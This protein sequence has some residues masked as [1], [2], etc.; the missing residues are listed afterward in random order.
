MRLEEKLEFF[1]LLL[2]IGFKEI[3]ISFPSAAQVEFDF[4]RKLIEEKL[5]PDDVTI[6]VL[7]QSREH[8]IERTFAA[9]KGAKRTVF[10]LYNSLS[11]L[12]RRVVFQKDRAAIK[13]IALNGIRYARNLA[14]DH[15]GEI[16]L[17]YS[18]ESFTG[19]EIDY[20]LEVCEAVC[21]AW[22]ATPQNK[23][24]LNLPATVELSTPNVY[25]DLVEIFTRS[26]SCRDSVIISLHTHND[27]GTAVAATEL[28]LMAGA[29]RVEGTLFGNGERTGNVDLV[30]LALNLFTQ[31]VDPHLDFRPLKRIVSEYNRLV[32][33]P[34][35]DRHPY[36]GELVFTAFSGS[37]QDAIAKGLQAQAKVSSGLYEV[38]YLPIDPQDIGREYEPIIRV[39]SQS[40][41]GGVAFILSSIFGCTVPKEAQ[42]YVGK[43]IQYVAES[44]G[45]EL[46]P[47]EIWNAFKE[48]FI[49]REDYL[50][51]V[52]FTTSFSALKELTT[53]QISLRYQKEDLPLITCS[54]VGPLAAACGA[55]L[56][57]FREKLPLKEELQVEI[58][59]YWQYARVS[60]ADAESIAFIEISSNYLG[61]VTELGVGLHASIQ[62]A[63]LLA[64]LAAFNR[65]LA[66]R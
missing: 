61:D 33:M 34:P 45:G 53:L 36:V 3:E 25:A 49:N 28:G 65:L 24:I 16:I 10:H 29:D 57:I 12:Q 26:L 8:L 18:P 15:D 9:I 58:K 48:K 19:T 46:T 31:G 56:K 54:G 63:S 37:H 62:K 51:L 22:G 59:N 1:A 47:E 43:V 6:Q 44:K 11:E 55:V 66:P 38:P 17:E 2:Q 64:L 50:S 30:T 32:R 21:E 23:V 52:E 5:I 7:T 40:G 42:P 4:T 60:G 39:N 20:S 27:R 41:K 14:K 13:E 35:H